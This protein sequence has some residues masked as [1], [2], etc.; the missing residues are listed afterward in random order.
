MFLTYPHLI[1]YCSSILYHLIILNT[2][3][4]SLLAEFLWFSFH[5]ILPIPSHLLSNTTSLQWIRI[6]QMPQYCTYSYCRKGNHKS[7]DEHLW[8]NKAFFHF[9]SHC[10][11]L[12]SALATSPT[13]VAGFDNIEALHSCTRSHVLLIFYHLSHQNKEWASVE[14]GEK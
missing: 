5:S 13:S 10:F 11:F 3:S 2:Q 7:N 12:H 4:F 14:K 9:F 6:T 1:C 8:S